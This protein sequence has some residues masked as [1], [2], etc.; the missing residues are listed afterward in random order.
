ME[1]V[2][3]RFPLTPVAR[4]V[5]LPLT[6][7]EQENFMAMLQPFIDHTGI[8]VDYTGTR[9]VNAVLTTQIQGGN[10]PNVAGVPGP[11]VAVGD[12][13]AVAVAGPG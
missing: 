8:Q 13:A 7:S 2:L 1:E 4:S 5:S 6:G 9:D 10:P 3:P 11:G 12:L